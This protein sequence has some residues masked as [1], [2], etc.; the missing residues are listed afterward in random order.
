MKIREGAYY[1]TRDGRTIGP[2]TPNHDSRYP[3]N[4]PHNG[5]FLLSYRDDGTICADNRDWDIVAEAQGS[6]GAS[7]SPTL[8]RDMTPE[9]K[10]GLLLAQLDGKA[11]QVS[12]GNGWNNALNPK[13]EP[14]C[15]YRVRSEPERRTVV[16]HGAGYEW[17]QSDLAAYG[18]THRITF[19]LLDGEP[20]CTSIKMEKL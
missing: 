12:R 15:A 14:D 10:G 4:I 2:A 5:G 11:I 17:C 19:D 18:D 6:A 20:D 3:W 1:R 16:L 9:Q 8:W 13:W 7:D